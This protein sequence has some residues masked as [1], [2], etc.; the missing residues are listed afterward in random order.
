VIALRTKKLFQV[1]DDLVE[2]FRIVLKFELV[3]PLVKKFLTENQDQ[4]NMNPVL[5]KEATALREITDELYAKEDRLYER[6]AF[7]K[8]P[9]MF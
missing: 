7:F 3:A 2:V 6:Y 4:Q 8:R 9:F 1:R 5:T